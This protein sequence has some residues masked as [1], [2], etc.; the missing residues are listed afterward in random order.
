MASMA[1]DDDDF[2]LDDYDDDMD[3]SDSSDLVEQLAAKSG[4]ISW[5]TTVWK[6]STSSDVNGPGCRE[7]SGPISNFRYFPRLQ[8]VQD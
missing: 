3:V 4:A 8:S 5:A 7:R 2:S 1:S 6:S